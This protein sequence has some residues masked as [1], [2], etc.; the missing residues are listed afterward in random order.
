M[1]SANFNHEL[2]VQMVKN[3]ADLLDNSNITLSFQYLE[4]GYLMDLMDD[5]NVSHLKI[6][7][8]SKNQLVHLYLVVV[9]VAEEQSVV[10]WFIG[11]Q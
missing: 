6:V 11:G 2:L 1:F 7:N 5:A 8:F 4:C 9:G 3:G 10:N